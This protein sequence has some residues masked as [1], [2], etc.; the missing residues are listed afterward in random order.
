LVIL[1]E[2][3]PNQLR[4]LNIDAT[5]V[6]KMPGRHVDFASMNIFITDI[7]EALEEVRHCPAS[8]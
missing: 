8:S 4:A 3:N 1:G 2:I 6:E 7:D 5:R